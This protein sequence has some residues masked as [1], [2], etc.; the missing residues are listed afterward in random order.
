MLIPAIYTDKLILNT[1]MLTASVTD[2]FTLNLFVISIIFGDISYV[3]KI[4]NYILSIS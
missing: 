3:Y 1:N 4:T 2:D